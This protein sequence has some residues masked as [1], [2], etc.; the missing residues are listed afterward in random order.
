[1]KNKAKKI[2]R[3][4]GTIYRANGAIYKATLLIKNEA[5]QQVLR[6]T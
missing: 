4:G 5:N 6:V 2:T 1:M 3:G